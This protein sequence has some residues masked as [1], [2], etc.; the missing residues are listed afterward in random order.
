MDPDQ[1]SPAPASFAPG[2]TSQYH[3]K[4]GQ[5]CSE[6][7]N[8]RRRKK[9][10][11][12]FCPNASTTNKNSFSMYFSAHSHS[13]QFNSGLIQYVKKSASHDNTGLH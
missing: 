9:K 6:S 1:K 2:L 11:A 10:G 3:I 8:K 12:S 7:G 13:Q 4:T 5:R